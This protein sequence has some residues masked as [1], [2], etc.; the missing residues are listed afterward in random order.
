[1]FGKLRLKAYAKINLCLDVIG[2][3]ED[4]YHL[5]ESVMQSV[6]LYDIVTVR[7][8][9]SEGIALKCSGLSIPQEK[10]IAYK[11]ATAFFKAV[12]LP[13]NTGVTIKIV[14]RIPSQ[15]GMGGGSSDAA[16]TL[17]ALNRLFKTKL[18]ETELCE[19][20][21]RVG[22]DV[23]FCICGGTRLVR[24]IGEIITKL[25]DCADCYFV[26][27][28]GND[29]VSTKEAY[30]CVDNA[31]DLVSLRVE[32]VIEA[33]SKGNFEALKGKLVNAFEQCT[34]IKDVAEIKE[35][36]LECGAVEAAMTGSGSAVFGIFTNKKQAKECKNKLREKYPFACIARPTVKGVD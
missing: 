34:K 19:I 25:D 31:K 8:S 30:E 16:A 13:D 4:G 14:K 20:G 5:L 11:A 15:A 12:G 6:S 26:I 36:L 3:R 21:E 28:K 18:S 32:K 2:I 22:A 29:G 24:G 27:A 1:M 7:R 23:P 9:N 17:V 33:L 10:N 35:I